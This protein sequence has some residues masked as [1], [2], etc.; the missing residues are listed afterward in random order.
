MCDSGPCR[1]RAGNRGTRLPVDRSE[2]HNGSSAVGRTAKGASRASTAESTGLTCWLL[3]WRSNWRARLGSGGSGGSGGAVP[4]RVVAP[5]GSPSGSTAARSRSA[6]ASSRCLRARTCAA[7]E[8]SR[9]PPRGNSRRLHL[10]D[11]RTAAH[12]VAGAALRGTGR[13]VV[14]HGSSTCSTIYVILYTAPCSPMR[15][16]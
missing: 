14:R 5:D 13:Q 3:Q 12:G 4:E 11:T 10:S 2:T 9:A 7:R 16:L 15:Y 8:C 6:R 1:G